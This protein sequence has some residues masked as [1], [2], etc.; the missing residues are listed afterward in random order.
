MEAVLQT[1]PEG[2]LIL[3]EHG[4]VTYASERVT[5]L[6]G[7]RKDQILTKRPR[8]WCQTPEVVDVLSRYETSSAPRYVSDAIHFHPAGKSDRTLAINGYPLYSSQNPAT[9]GGSLIVISD[10]TQEAMAK[11][12]RA[13]FV[14]HLGH[15]L[16]TPLNTLALYSEV[17]LDDNG[18]NP[19]ERI[20][21]INTIHDE[22]ERMAGLINNLLNIARIE[23]GSLD[24]EKQRVRIG[25]L[26]EDISDNLGQ[27]AA[28]Q[29]IDLQVDLPSNLSPIFVD[30]DLMRVAINNFV[31]NAIKYNQAGGTVSI[32]AEETDEAMLIHI[33]D[34]GIGI[35]GDDQARIF[36]KF[37]RSENSEVRTRTGHGLGLPLARQIVELHDGQVS[38]ESELGSGSKFTISLWKRFGLIK[39]AI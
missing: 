32:S 24:L 30:K 19:A 22:V 5:T 11:Q 29:D 27:L 6:L 26:L 23:M 33:E 31:S 25:D 10:V 18:E 9:L 3:D 1:L 14:A 39:R 15:E 2:L 38:V 21:A 34:S 13:E 28:R 16:K 36:E 37:F 4:K 12:S 17:L 20:E 35:G 7:A 8:E